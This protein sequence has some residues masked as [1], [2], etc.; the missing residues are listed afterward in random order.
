MSNHTLDVMMT[1]YNAERYLH[2]AL[3]SIQNQTFRDF[4]LI[5]IDDGSTD[6]SPDILSQFAA[7]DARIQII[8]QT[9]QGVVKAANRGMSM[10]TAPLIARMD[11]D[12]IAMPTRLE[13]QVQFMAKHPD[14]SVVGT[15]ILEIDAQ[16][17][18]LAT[19]VYPTE[20]EAIDAANMQV[21]TSL[22]HPTVMFRR[23]AFNALGG[24]REAFRYVEDL[25]MWLRLAEHGRL[26]NLPDVLLCYRQHTDS[27]SWNHTGEKE[28]RLIQ[29]LQTTYERRGVELPQSLVRRCLTRRSPGGPAKWARKA[30]RQGHW[31][32]ALKHLRAQWKRSPLDF[33]TWRM[34]V[35]VVARSAASSLM[36]HRCSFPEVP[37]YE[38]AA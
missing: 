33:V 36:G 21:K 25:D 4:R 22:A 20:H 30:A 37:R 29:L 7:A 19:V 31:D 6:Q 38:K 10:C 14:V 26:A 27:I 18:P 16:S 32:V 8:R 12:D 24:Y 15:S 9:N 3:G 35:E 2:D 11:S 17:Q 13:K 1:V 23:D 34:S 28:E 5:C